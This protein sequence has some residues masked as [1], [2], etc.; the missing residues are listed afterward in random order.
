VPVVDFQQR[1]DL[2]PGKPLGDDCSLDR[3]QLELTL[4]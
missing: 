3:M 1:K 2:A 4:V